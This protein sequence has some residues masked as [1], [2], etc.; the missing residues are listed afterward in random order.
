V[1]PRSFITGSSLRRVLAVC[2][3]LLVTSGCH[4]G[5]ALQSY[6]V[7]WD[8]ASNDV[9]AWGYSEMRKASTT[10]AGHGTISLDPEYFAQRRSVKVRDAF[11]SVGYLDGG[12]ANWTYSPAGRRASVPCGEPAE[13]GAN[14]RRFVLGPIRNVRITSYAYRSRNFETGWSRTLSFD[15]RIAPGTDLGRAL[16]R[17]GALL[18]DVD[19]HVTKGTSG[20]DETD[21]YTPIQKPWTQDR[22]CQGA[23]EEAG[24]EESMIP[25]LEPHLPL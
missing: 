18:C 17:R 13:L 11:L 5:L 19:W 12:H 24:D 8:K 7:D 15:Y 9:R 1:G 14:C 10:W 21:D 6:S 4:T 2:A 25:L 16:A 23:V 3:T 20:G 22:W